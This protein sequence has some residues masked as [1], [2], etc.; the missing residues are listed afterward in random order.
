MAH[1]VPGNLMGIRARVSEW[2]YEWLSDCRITPYMGITK[3]GEGA[4]SETV[5]YL[6]GIAD[7]ISASTTHIGIRGWEM[8]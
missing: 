3:R 8:K 4:M 1:N 7:A 5:P 2:I 6:A